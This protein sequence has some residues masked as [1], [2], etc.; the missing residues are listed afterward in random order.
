MDSRDELIEARKLFDQGSVAEASS[1]AMRLLD[2]EP[3]LAEAWHLMARVARVANDLE[4]AER[5][6]NV[7]ISRNGD[8]LEAWLERAQILSALNRTTDAAIAYQRVLELDETSFEAHSALGEIYASQGQLR[9]AAHHFRRAVQIF[10][11]SAETYNQLGEVLDRLGLNSEAESALSTCLG[12]D[13][14]HLRALIRMGNL[15][16]DRHHPNRARDFYARALSLR[17]N[18][19]YIL[20]N[21][22]NALMDL[23]DAAAALHVYQRSLGIYPEQP[24]THSNFLFSL[25][26]VSGIPPGQIVAAHVEWNRRFAKSIQPLGSFEGHDFSERRPLK[27]GFISADFRNHPVGRFA[28]V[29]FESLNPAEIS[30]FAYYPGTREDQVTSNIQKH[31]TCWRSIHKMG[32]AQIATLAREDRLDALLDLS[33]HT[34]GNCLLVFP[35]RAAPIQMSTWVYPGTT[36]LDSIDF[37]LTDPYADPESEDTS[38]QPEKLVRLPSISWIYQPPKISPEPVSA[39]CL[40]G[41]PFTFGCLNNPNKI[42]AAAIDLWSSL[43]R[44]LPNARLVMLT[45]DE[46]EH[47]AFLKSRFLKSGVGEGQLAF[48]PRGSTQAYL[49]YHAEIDLMLDPFP[50]NGCTT[51]CDSLWMGVPVLTLAGDYYVSRQ[52]VSFLKNLQMPEC[53]ASSPAEFVEK[54]VAL[55]ESPERTNQLRTGL[56]EKLQASPLMDYADYAQSFT[57]LLRELWHR[58]C[59]DAG[60]G[61]A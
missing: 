56:R 9:P 51:T 20:S 53:I 2:R 23:G 34:S 8:L 7:A 33:G 59:R 17:P 46:S 45:W 22:A 42:S 19:P 36:G 30:T 24:T 32:Y 38:G 52:G 5:M 37:R 50:Y 48:R 26:Y 35:Y 1:L 54:A 15:S 40:A 57:A 18:D 11:Q 12:L 28:E 44:R 29:L 55:A 27:V 4:L 31:A 10:P 6:I 13:P 16:R 47:A 43:L 41:N 60:S 39:P 61:P 3:T 14:N 58:R 25:H 49:S 21:L